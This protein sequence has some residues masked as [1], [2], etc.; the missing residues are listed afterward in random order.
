[1]SQNEIKRY[2]KY[3]MLLQHVKSVSA[4][5]RS[6]TSTCQFQQRFSFYIPSYL[7]HL[8]FADLRLRQGHLPWHFALFFFTCQTNTWQSFF[9]SYLAGQKRNPSFFSNE[10][11]EKVRQDLAQFRKHTEKSLF[12][13]IRIQL[14]YRRKY[15][16]KVF[17]YTI[18]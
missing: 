4:I 18:I 1:M 16:E 12:V 9:M 7:P 2:L 11:R 15:F 13:R 6:S 14:E 3:S 8:S 10:Q 17:F 5:S